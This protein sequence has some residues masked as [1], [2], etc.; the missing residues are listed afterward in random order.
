MICIKI[1]HQDVSSKPLG[2]KMSMNP[3]LMTTDQAN[4]STANEE[5]CSRADDLRE[6][7]PDQNSSNQEAPAPKSPRIF[8]ESGEQ[9]FTRS[10]MEKI[11]RMISHDLRSPLTGIGSVLRAPSSDL[12]ENRQ[13]LDQAALKI[14]QIARLMQTPQ[15]YNRYLGEHR[16]PVKTLAQF[17][18]Y[19]TPFLLEEV[20]AALVGEWTLNEEA[21]EKLKVNL[22]FS[23][24]FGKFMD[25]EYIDIFRK[26][27]D[28]TYSI[29]RELGF[30]EVIA[31]NLMSRTKSHYIT[32]SFKNFTGSPNGRLER[33]LVQLELST[34]LSGA[35][36]R[37]R[38]SANSY[39]VEVHI[40]KA[41]IPPWFCESFKV[42]PKS[43]VLVV[44]DDP[45]VQKIYK[46]LFASFDGEVTYSSGGA[47]VD[48][49]LQN[50]KFDSYFFDQH[51]G[52]QVPSGLEIIRKFSIKGHVT[53]I[54]SKFHDQQFVDE[55]LELGARVIPKDYLTYIERDIPTGFIANRP[56]PFRA[57]FISRDKDAMLSW[58]ERFL[59]NSDE[60]SLLIVPTEEE[61]DH[62]VID[63]SAVPVY[64]DATTIKGDLSE[65][66]RRT[67]K[68]GFE[69]IHLIVP[70]HWQNA[71]SSLY[72]EVRSIAS[73][74]RV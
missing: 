10:Q 47:E 58:S 36:V 71:Y 20:M 33:N 56:F 28:Y 67:S 9:L 7:D 23:G 13:L 18:H 44:E 22:A 65:L 35:A 68:R 27:S 48:Q 4:S 46:T 19:P 42:A 30:K 70:K 74:E 60:S 57:V 32:I 61:L 73:G 29:V 66:A 43:R 12:E 52:D 11:L 21:D 3:D 8:N 50:N 15:Y 45:S 51:L 69:N 62:Y 5:S 1:A 34:K 63:D 55:L 39:N 41:D 25:P 53:L 14:A 17:E 6:S 24:V 54:T 64:V 26:I 72:L 59:N 40:P 16:V 31:I 2:E 49:I 37:A 38:A